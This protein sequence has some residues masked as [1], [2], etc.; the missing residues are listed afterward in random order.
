MKLGNNK[1]RKQNP[2]KASAKKKETKISKFYEKGT[3]V[4]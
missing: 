3:K 2:P 1:N 4:Q